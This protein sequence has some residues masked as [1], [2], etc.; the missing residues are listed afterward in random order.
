LT[1][2]NKL[3]FSLLFVMGLLAPAA[4]AHP[5][6]DPHELLSKSFQQAD[7]WNQGPVKLVAKMNIP[8]PDGTNVT[9]QLTD[10]WAAPDKWRAEWTANGLDQVTVLNDNKLFYASNPPLTIV[11]ILQFELAIAVLDGGNPAG[12]YSAP[13]IDW[14]KAKIDTTK[15]KI[16]GIDAK[17]MAFGQPAETFCIDP[18]NGHLLSFDSDYTTFEY[19][20]YVT[21]G[22]NSYPQTIKV[23]YAKSPIS[24]SK[25]TVSRGDKFADSLFTAPEK[26]TTEVFSSCA[27]V[28]KNFTAPRLQKIVKAKMPDAARKA[29]QYGLV[30]TVATVD[31]NGAVQ[32][33]TVLGGNPALKDAAI[34]A[35][36]QYKYTPYMRCGQ[37]VEFQKL[38]VVPFAPPQK[39]PE[40]GNLP[41]R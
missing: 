2:F 36:Q 22:S 6:E 30:Y 12:P 33:V 34:Q 32:K 24:E 39:L 9:L 3:F 21:I 38:V 31:K 15:K 26:S 11:Q 16:N 7:I 17:C 41:T 27:D 40:E 29:Q 19:S 8:K 4:F 10:S 37:A 1:Q 28:Q 23:S 25:L 5:R 20:D 35:V 13:P 14:E 18:A